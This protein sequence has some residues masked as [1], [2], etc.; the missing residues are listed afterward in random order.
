MDNLI[1]VYENVLDKEFCQKLIDKYEESEDAQ[2]KTSTAGRQFTEIPMHNYMSVWGDE[3]IVCLNS[4]HGII[5]NYKQEIGI[6]PINSSKPKNA[7]WPEQ[8]GMEGIKIKRYLPNDEDEFNWHVDVNDGQSNA[9]FLAFFVYLD[10]NDAGET[11]FG[12]WIGDFTAKCVAGSAI[13]FPPMWP[14]LHRGKKPINK[15][16]YLLQSYLH[17]VSPEVLGEPSQWEFESIERLQKLNQKEK[18]KQLISNLIK[19]YPNS[20]KLKNARCL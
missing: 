15:P 3:F 4:F 17:Y 10:D 20:E 5:E 8:Y 19:K 18:T 6:E 16:K 9:R 13:L 12:G 11:E 2:S 7:L 1:R 14:W